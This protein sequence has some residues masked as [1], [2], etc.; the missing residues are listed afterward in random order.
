[1]GQIVKISTAIGILFG[2]PLQL[3]V[4]IVVLYPMVMLKCKAAANNP[5]AGEFLFRILMV[6]VTLLVVEFIPKLNLL[7]SLIGAFCGT[8]ETFPI[9]LR[10]ISD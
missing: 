9:F 4:V 10:G 8:C 3:Y 1:M 7:L 5:L 2:Y 6:F